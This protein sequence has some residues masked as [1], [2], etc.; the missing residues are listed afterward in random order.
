[1]SIKKLA[2]VT[3]F[4]GRN[5]VDC[6]ESDALSTKTLVQ[7][8][9]ESDALS[10]DDS[11]SKNWRERS[12]FSGG[13][14]CNKLARVTPVQRLNLVQKTGESDAS[15]TEDSGSKNWRE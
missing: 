5:L 6:G 15:S 13:I 4:Q 14:L 9:G 3:P 11:G 2:R 7:K 1:M 8:T 12:S 10:A